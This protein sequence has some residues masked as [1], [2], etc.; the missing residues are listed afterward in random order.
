MI[1]PISMDE[2]LELCD[3]YSKEFEDLDFA[4]EYAL[5]ANFEHYEDQLYINQNGLTIEEFYMVK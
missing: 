3:Q 2:F 5:A 4:R 1:D